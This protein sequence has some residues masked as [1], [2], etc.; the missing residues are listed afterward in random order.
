LGP[1]RAG[2]TICL[3]YADRVHSCHPTTLSLVVGRS[4]PSCW[5]PLFA[6]GLLSTPLNA[7][8]GVPPLGKSPVIHLELSLPSP[9][10]PAEGSPIS[11]IPAWAPWILSVAQLWRGHA[12][13]SIAAVPSRQ[14]ILAAGRSLLRSSCLEIGQGLLPHGQLITTIGCDPPIERQADRRR[15]LGRRG[16]VGRVRV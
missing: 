16:R 11:S 10:V 2:V 3:R 5:P 12:R 14:R 9:A 1:L 6:N 15:G 7:T 8:Y 4:F 13:G